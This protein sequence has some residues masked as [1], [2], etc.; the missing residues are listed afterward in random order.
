M[1][2]NE[3]L[4]NKLAS[5]YKQADR[6]LNLVPELDSRTK[7]N[8]N[9]T[10]R[11]KGYRQEKA[12]RLSEID[13]NN[14]T[15]HM[16]NSPMTNIEDMEIAPTASATNDMQLAQPMH[17][18]KLDLPNKLRD[19]LT[20]KR[21]SGAARPS[22]QKPLY[23]EPKQQV[24]SFNPNAAYVSE[25]NKLLGDPSLAEHRPYLERYLKPDAV[26]EQTLQQF[27]SKIQQLRGTASS[28]YE[29]NNLQKLASHLAIMELRLKKSQ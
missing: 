6:G 19:G 12:E 22:Y 25:Y 20:T 24:E 11:D 26:N 2:W 16:T 3:Y 27:R 21:P 9:R 8:A 14:P 13:P 23:M 4:A 28:V 29:A 10:F 1:S 18:E 17:E 15:P 7:G 5:F